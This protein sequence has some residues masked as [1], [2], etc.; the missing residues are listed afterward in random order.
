LTELEWFQGQARVQDEM[1]C[2]TLIEH[3]ATHTQP[4]RFDLD[5][6]PF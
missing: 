5:R 1:A 6:L 3:E 2:F 4:S